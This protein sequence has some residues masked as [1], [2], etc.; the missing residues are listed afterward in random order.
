VTHFLI[1]SQIIY[2]PDLFTQMFNMGDD[3]AVHTWS[4]PYMTTQTNLQVVAEVSMTRLAPK[5]DDYLWRHD[6]WVG[7]CS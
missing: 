6:S 2:L 5:D 4:H 7:R 3:L 1:G